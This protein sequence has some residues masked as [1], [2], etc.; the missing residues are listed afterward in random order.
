MHFSR[1]FRLTAGGTDGF[2]A[3]STNGINSPAVLSSSWRTGLYTT[4]KTITP[5][6]HGG[7]T[8]LHAMNLILVKMFATALALAQVTT[9]PDSLKTEFDPVNDQAAVVQ[10][11]KDGCAHMRKAFDIEDLNLDSLIETAMSDPQTVTGEIRAFRG[12]NF[13]DLAAALI[14]AKSSGVLSRQMSSHLSRERPAG[15]RNHYS[16]MDRTG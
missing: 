16:S 8:G 10:I 12:I 13:D 14:S 9:R 7:R 2:G 6:T 11:L 15:C 4:T 5:E 1:A 3:V